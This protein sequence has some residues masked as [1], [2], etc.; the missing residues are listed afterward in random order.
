MSDETVAAIA[1]DL[2]KALLARAKS[3]S[4]DDRKLVLSLQTQ[5]VAEIYEE[6]KIDQTSLILN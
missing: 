5:L 2:A 4:A 6:M 3:R 1:R